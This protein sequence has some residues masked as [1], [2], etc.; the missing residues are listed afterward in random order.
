MN[1][2]SPTPSFTRGPAASPTDSRIGETPKA[3]VVLRDGHQATEQEV[4]AFCREQ[5]GSTKKVTSVD[6]VEE[7][8]K[9]PVG[10][11]L[12]RV[13]KEPYWGEVKVGGA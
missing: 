2:S 5:V 12:R 7:I 9:T 8:P 1:T 4:I 3:V 11:V 10:K 6:F 13:L